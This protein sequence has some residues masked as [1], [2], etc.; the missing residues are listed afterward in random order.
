[1]AAVTTARWT[2]LRD[3]ALTAIEEIMTSGSSVAYQ[4]RSLTMANITELRQAVDWFQAQ[5]DAS[6]GTARRSTISYIVPVV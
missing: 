2:E 6:G 1:M 5:I 3:A 4:G